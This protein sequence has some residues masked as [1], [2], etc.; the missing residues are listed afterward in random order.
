MDKFLEI[1]EK[2]CLSLLVVCLIGLV[3][4][5]AMTY[6]AEKVEHATSIGRHNHNV[7]TSDSIVSSSDTPVR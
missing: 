3:A 5:C 2:L 7:V 6:R 4:S 1:G